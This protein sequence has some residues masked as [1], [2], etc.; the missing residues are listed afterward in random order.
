MEARKQEL[1]GKR[2]EL[3]AMACQN[4]ICNQL[5]HSEILDIFLDKES[6]TDTFLVT[7]VI[8]D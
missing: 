7:S 8:V 1:L 2:L 3:Y 4:N 6:V 5:F